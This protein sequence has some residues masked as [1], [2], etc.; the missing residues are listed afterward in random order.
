MPDAHRLRELRD[1]NGV[2]FRVAHADAAVGIAVEEACVALLI[3]L[4]Q[5]HRA[6]LRA[7]KLNVRTS[8]D[9]LIQRR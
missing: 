4:R 5:L 1:S 6:F 2:I 7:W 8:R 9:C 3:P